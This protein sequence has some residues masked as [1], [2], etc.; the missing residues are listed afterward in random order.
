MQTTL[1]IPYGALQRLADVTGCKASLLSDYAAGRKRPGRDRAV[2]LEVA[3]G[4]NRHLWLY[5]T[6]D[7]LKPAIIEAAKLA[8]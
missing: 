6:P 2:D 7:E 1:H 5:G 8:A 4:I 3:T